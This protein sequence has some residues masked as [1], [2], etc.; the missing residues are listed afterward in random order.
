[1]DEVLPGGE[2]RV[3]ENRPLPVRARA[4]GLGGASAPVEVR[5]VQFGK[6]I[7]HAVA[8][9]AETTTLQ[10]ETTVPSGNGSWLAVHAI[11]RDGSEAHTT[12]VYVV[13]EG[14]RFWDP[15]QADAILMQ[16]LVI[17]DGIDE[18]LRNAE[19]RAAAHPD[20][21][22]PWHQLIADQANELRRRIQTARGRYQQLQKQLA[23]ERVPGP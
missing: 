15:G 5:L 6:T 2:I 14:F 23:E 18:T 12:P 13:R 22:D 1:V 16:Q 17:L 11:G 19:Q 3:T 4:W 8:E 21:L 9:N 7:R 20:G 10:I